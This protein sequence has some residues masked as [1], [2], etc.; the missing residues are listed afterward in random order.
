MKF[1]DLKVGDWFKR[2]DVKSDNIYIKI[3]YQTKPAEPYFNVCIIKNDYNI[4]GT[5]TYWGDNEEVEYCPSINYI[6]KDKT[7]KNCF[8]PFR[9]IAIGELFY[10]N[11]SNSI[12][13]KIRQRIGIIIYTAKS[14]HHMGEK[15]K[16]RLSENRC[17]IKKD[18]SL[19]V[20]EVEEIALDF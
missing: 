16:T 10:L 18:L 5:L 19:K 9:E 6:A 11:N 4:K 12:A 7:Y 2:A 14:A 13:I 8:K 15:C 20:P 17:V 3:N 1:K